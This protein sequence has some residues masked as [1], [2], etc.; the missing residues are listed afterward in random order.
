MA[1]LESPA[2]PPNHRPH[3]TRFLRS[4]RGYILYPFAHAHNPLYLHLY[5]NK[6]LFCFLTLPFGIL[7][8]V[9]FYLMRTIRL[10]TTSSG[11]RF[12]RKVIKTKQFQMTAG[13]I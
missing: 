6:Y 13:F 3:S 1:R 5:P 2:S 7:R 8:E 4:V 12:V 10:C 11:T 9:A